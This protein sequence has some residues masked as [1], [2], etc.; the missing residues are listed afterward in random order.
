[1]SD[2]LLGAGPVWLNTFWPFV[3]AARNVLNAAV[4]PIPNGGVR[5]TSRIGAKA[6]LYME[7]RR[8]AE[9]WKEVVSAQLDP[10]GPNVLC[11]FALSYRDVALVRALLPMWDTFDKTVLMIEDMF[12]PEIFPKDI[13]ERFDLITVFCGDLAEEFKREFDTEVIHL[14]PHLDVLGYHGLSDYRPLDM[15]LVGR[16]D[17]SVH[18]PIF[19]HFNRA[20]SDRLF[21]DF[22]TRTQLNQ[23]LEEEFGL[24][25]NTYGR[26]K[27]AF[28]Y[29]PSAI[30]RFRGHSPMTGRHIHAWAAG[31][32]VMGA[33]PTGRG[34]AEAT[35]WPEAIIDLPDDPKRAIALAGD[36][37]DDTEGLA[38]RRRR[39]V[40]EAAERHD[41]RLR[42]RQ[43][44]QELSLP[45]PAG[46]AEGLTELGKFAQ[47]LREI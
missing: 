45:L 33:R 37:L 18:G 46:L 26:S 38:R 2:D 43:I 7:T 5:R 13:C 11:V 8:L 6:Q 12:G 10:N 1:M 34:V 3:N 27:I 28:A 42:F 29:E 30:P 4:L 36:V 32:T 14:P 24:L 39:N 31:C 44:F 16:R 41:T 35:D 40:I 19:R 15:V 20:E 22:V 17:N 23:T 47:Q 21:V 9:T 25:M